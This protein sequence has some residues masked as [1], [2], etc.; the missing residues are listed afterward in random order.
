MLGTILIPVILTLFLLVGIFGVIA[1]YTSIFR[2]NHSKLIS[3]SI[4]IGVIGFIP[5][6]MG[7]T[8]IVNNY[9]FGVF[10]YKY[11]ENV[12]E[13]KAHL[14][15]TATN[16]NI[17]TYPQGYKAK[18]NI[19]ETSLNKW[20]DDIWKKSNNV[21]INSKQ[22]KENITEYELD[23]FHNTFKKQGWILPASAI[24]YNG[25]RKSNGAGFTLYFDNEDNVAYQ[26]VGYW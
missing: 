19:T 15:P 4:L 21:S 13:G 8:S 25:P 12:N 3:R 10:H 1:I 14:P 26:R 7:I 23:G 5:S 11:Y 24:V 16:I 6:C 20:F 22:R 18:F 9:R 17:E 2:K